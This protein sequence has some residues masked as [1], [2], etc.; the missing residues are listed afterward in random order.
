MADGAAQ[1]ALGAEAASLSLTTLAV[2]TPC[3]VVCAVGAAG[4]EAVGVGASIVEVVNGA[5]AGDFDHVATGSFSLATFGASRVVT[6]SFSR[7][8]VRENLLEDRLAD[9]AVF[10]T[11][12]G[13]SSAARLIVGSLGT[14]AND[15]ERAITPS[16]VP[17]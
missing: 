17:G 2:T 14:A 4:A 10:I 8:S 11:I 13:P 15:L 7:Q 3:T 16:I 5:A 1:L 12:E 9:F 6:T